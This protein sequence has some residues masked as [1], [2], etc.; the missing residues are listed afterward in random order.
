MQP[1]TIPCAFDNL[2]YLLICPETGLA[3]VVDPT[4]AWPV[5][6]ALEAAG[7][8]LSAVLCT[9]HH[10]DHLDGL[11]DLL[12]E[13]PELQVYGFAGDAGRID[14]LNQ[15]V[16]DGAAIAIGTLQGR[17]LHTPGHTSGS[18]CYHF[19]STLFTGDTLF[20][21]GCGRLFE[22]SPAQMLDS[23]TGK[24]SHLDPA[25]RLC[26]GHDYTKKNLAFA[27]LIEPDNIEIPR[28]LSDLDHQGG[29]GG[30]VSTLAL[31][32]LTNPFLRCHL[33]AVRASLPAVSPENSDLEVFTLLRQLRDRF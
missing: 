26:Y 5:W 6:Q 1:V 29:N 33:P 27:R 15:P 8:K 18:L 2:S 32:L 13:Q 22:G 24:I 4:E 19:G 25:T 10:R 17:V 21:A 14:R 3:A 11:A 28:R 7:A 12:A 30:Q 31:E 9:H 16:T 23:L 20:G